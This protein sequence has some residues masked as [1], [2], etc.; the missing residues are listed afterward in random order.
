MNSLTVQQ[1]RRL[2]LKFILGSPL[3]CLPGC[4][5]SETKTKELL[6]QASDAINVFDFEEFAK[7]KLPPAHFGYLSTG[8]NDDLTIKANREAFMKYKLKMR[9]L[10]GVSD[11]DMSIELFG[12]KWPTPIVLSPVGSQRAFHDEGELATARAAK[13]RN[14][15]QILSTVTTSSVE[16]VSRERGEPVWYQLYPFTDWSGTLNM[17]QRAENAGSEVLVLTVDLSSGTDNRETLKRM[18]KLDTRTCSNCHSD[19]YFLRK[20][21]AA[22]IKDAVFEENLDW[23]YVD[24]IKNATKMKLVIKGIE[25]AEDAQL[26]LDHKVD[27]II[28]SN[29]GGRASESG[30]GTLE[31]LSEILKIVNGQVPVL[32]DGG[33]RRGT[34]IF[35]ALA[36]GANAV[37]IGRPYIWGLASFG[38]SGVEAVLRILS[39]ELAL[40]MRQAG[41]ARIREITSK[42]L[43]I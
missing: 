36:L 6:R 35:K 37:C 11:V 21:M 7:Q 32:I 19:N 27:G 42:Y 1:Q 22:S 26:C 8:V 25:T 41:T 29:H 10:T 4:F 3:L 9:R 30:R 16:D 13:S 24:K 12:K 40:T 14:H 18:I 34:D 17:I 33:F 15:L 28:I 20:P 31:C 23:E 2:L 43:I 39:D 5:A 38:Q